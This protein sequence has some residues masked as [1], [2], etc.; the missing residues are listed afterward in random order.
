MVEE[1]NTS[2][3]SGGDAF[4]AETLNKLTKND[5]INLVLQ[6]NAEKQ[7][8]EE[9]R[10]LLHEINIRVIALERSQ[11]LHEQYGRRESVEI[12]GIPTTVG[13]HNLEDEVIKVY[14]AA[15]VQVFGRQLMKEDISAC[16]RIGKK[17][18][19]TIVR[20]VNRKF[21]FA[22]LVSGKNLKGKNI[23]NDSNIYINNSFCREFGKY[24]YFIRRLKDKKQI[25][26]YRIRN[27]V[28]EIQLAQNDDYVQIS[29]VSDFATLNLDIEQF[30]KKRE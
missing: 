20:F 19:T 17:Q 18:Q 10:K 14:N 3:A 22:G 5:L 29:H 21:A 26:G 27:G 30:N 6:L 24:G 2:A 16:H 11:Y 13:I 23:Y 1:A 8:M 25:C 9:E 15:E 4:N 28:Y 12:T 7:A